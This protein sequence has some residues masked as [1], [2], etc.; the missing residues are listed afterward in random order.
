M[1]TNISTII[2]AYNESDN[3]ENLLKKIRE[4]IKSNIIIIDDSSNNLTKSIL[5]KK[6]IKVTYIKRHRKMGRGSAVLEG[7]K[8]ALKNKKIEIFI[9]MDADLSH[10]PSELRR[11]KIFQRQKFRFVDW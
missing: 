3:I 2:P 4:N 10:P 6:K 7:L 8:K 9:E 11:N 1:S 5:I